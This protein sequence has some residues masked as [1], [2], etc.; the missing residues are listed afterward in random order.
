MNAA[1][2]IT[3]QATSTPAT[4]VEP[5]A[6]SWTRQQYYAMGDAGVFD[7]PRVELIDGKIVC[8]SPRKGNHAIVIGLGQRL[9]DQLFSE[10][11]YVRVQL[12]IR[13]FADS[14]PEP[15]SGARFGFAYGVK[16]VYQPTDHVTPLA[17]PNALITVADLLP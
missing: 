4:D 12:P 1:E 8:V 15:D 13:G 17:Q 11:T 14:E 7:G 3:T 16:Q 2:T 6:V 5:R 10:K 9:L